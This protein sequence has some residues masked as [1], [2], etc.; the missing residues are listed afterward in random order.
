MARSRDLIARVARLTQRLDHMVPDE[1]LSP[2]ENARASAELLH[3]T[4][5]L[6][7]LLPDPSLGP[8]ERLERFVRVAEGAQPKD[9]YLRSAASK[10]EELTTR[11]NELVPEEG[12]TPEEKIDVLVRRVDE[13]VGGS[14]SEA[15]Q[16]KLG[17]PRV[18]ETPEEA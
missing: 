13:Q 15:M 14:G 11:L 8:M 17:D 5:K 12:F 16:E 1:L 3:L 4:S 6:S 7:D 2:D 18:P 9:E 10:L